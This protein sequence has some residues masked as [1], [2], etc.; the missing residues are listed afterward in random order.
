MR[1]ADSEAS[2]T[3][4]KYRRFDPILS[5]VSS[6]QNRNSQGMTRLCI[7]RGQVQPGNAPFVNLGTNGGRRRR[8]R[9]T[10]GIICREVHGLVGPAPIAGNISGLSEGH[11]KYVAPVQVRPSGVVHSA[12]A[13]DYRVET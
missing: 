8:H 12:Q 4:C 6:G 1:R 5:P 11:L 2:S 10:N 13:L 3:T 9:R 7:R